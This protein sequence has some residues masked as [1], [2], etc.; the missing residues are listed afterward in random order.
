MENYQSLSI[1]LLKMKTSKRRTLIIVFTFLLGYSGTTFSQ[2]KDTLQTR[3]T[4]YFEAFGQ[5]L[6]NSLNYDR[7]V[8]VASNFK[9]SLTVGISNWGYM[10]DEPHFKIRAIG[11]PVSYNYLRGRKNH[12]FELGLGAT[13]ENIKV[14]YKSILFNLFF[15]NGSN[16]QFNDNIDVVYFNLKAGYR[17]QKPEGGFFFRYTLTP[18]IP[19][20]TKDSSKTDDGTNNFNTTYSDFSSSSLKFFPW[21]GVSFGYSF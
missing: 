7:I 5:G 1:N 11:I 14:E 10:F 17:Y 21:M 3:N 18:I 19:L 12:H 20:Y 2:Q 16:D 4:I 6:I 8:T 15:D 13:Y 9:T